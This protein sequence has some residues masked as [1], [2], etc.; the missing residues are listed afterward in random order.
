V[1]LR[2]IAKGVSSICRY[3]V[4]DTNQELPNISMDTYALTWPVLSFVI[5]LSLAKL[6]GLSRVLLEKLTVAQLDHQIPRISWSLSQM[7]PLFTCLPNF[8]KINF[9]MNPYR[10]DIINDYGLEETVFESWQGQEFFLFSETSTPT[11]RPSKLHTQW[12]SAFFPGS[13]ATE[14]YISQSP[15]SNAQLTN[16]STRNPSMGLWA[17]KSCTGSS[18]TVLGPSFHAFVTTVEPFLQVS[19]LKIYTNFHPFHGCYAPA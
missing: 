15:S 13:K 9:K 14:A 10:V 11:L 2:I 17:F 18:L 5:I 7:N 3:T 19:K 1:G 12:I 8:C 6:S 16:K 4:R